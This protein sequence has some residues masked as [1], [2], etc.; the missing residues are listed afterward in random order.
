MK[1]ALTILFILFTYGIVK[2][3]NNSQINGRVLD[4]GSNEPL[5]Y[6]SV[7]V[8]YGD[9]IIGA[10][11]DEDGNFKIKPLSAGTYNLTVNY[12][13]KDTLK[14]LGI[15][16]N[17]NEIKPIGDIFLADYA[18]KTVVVTAVSKNTLLRQDDPSVQGMP[19]EQVENLP[20]R[21]DPVA[22]L[23]VVATGVTVSDDRSK[24]I[25]RGAREDANTYY[26]DGMRVSSLDGA[27]PNGS[28]QSINVYTGGIPAQ[29]GDVTGGVVVIET[30]SY[31][32]LYN[33]W[34]YS[35]QE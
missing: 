16:L 10:V 7:Y 28:I 31:F 27:V 26:V 18:M 8:E 17:P 19:L 25:I 6:A 29:Y 4:K 15:I 20:E 34:K 33:Q 23:D 35:Q 22:I 13:G 9:K 3:Q 32:D 12:T 14:L 2:S 30:K 11:T 24:I 1:K 21:N 5:P